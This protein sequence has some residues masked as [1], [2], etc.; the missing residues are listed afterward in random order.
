MK[1]HSISLAM[2][3]IQIK[4][5]RHLY[6]RTRMAKIQNTIYTYHDPDMIGS[7]IILILDMIQLIDIYPKEMKNVVQ[8]FYS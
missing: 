1:R 3:E 4:T 2:R 5:T 6:T 7:T 8:R